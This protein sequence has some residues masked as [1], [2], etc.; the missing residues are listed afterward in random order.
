MRHYE[1]FEKSVVQPRLDSP[2]AG[3]QIL[4]PLSISS[5]ALLNEIP[6][7]EHLIVSCT[8]D[9]QNNKIRSHSLIDNDAT[10]YAFVNKNFVRCH[11]FPMYKLKVSRALEIIDDRLIE[12]E[13][14]TH[15]T[16][17]KM[18]ID[19]HEEY[20]LMFITKLDHYLFVLE[21]P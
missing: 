5:I 6:K 12:S 18:T 19:K 17:I 1:I 9:D 14:I 2:V 10:D 7:R 16:K 4:D 20:L 13:D 21:N 3:Q 15:M 11:N 8:I